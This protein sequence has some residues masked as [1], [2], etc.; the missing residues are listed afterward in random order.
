[1]QEDVPQLFFDGL[2]VFI[3]DGIRQ[4]IGFLDGELTKRLNGLLAVPGALFP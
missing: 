1:V 3:G 2:P 4:L